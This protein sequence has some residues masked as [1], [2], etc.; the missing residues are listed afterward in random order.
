MTTKSFILKNKHA[1]RRLPSEIQQKLKVLMNC[2]TIT[3]FIINREEKTYT[4][5]KSH[6]IK[7]IQMKDPK[8]YS[9]KY[10][11]E[12]LEDNK[13]TKLTLSV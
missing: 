8:Q 1:T 9:G 3:G 10:E 12:A 6:K 7:G 4:F 11:L 2:Y 5:Y 13:T